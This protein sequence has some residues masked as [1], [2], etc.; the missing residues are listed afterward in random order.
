MF[1]NVLDLIKVI[2]KR[3]G[4]QMSRRVGGV[5]HI[6]VAPYGNLDTSTF[7]EWSR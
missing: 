2:F 7:L 3:D 4:M 6:P 5:H 1:S